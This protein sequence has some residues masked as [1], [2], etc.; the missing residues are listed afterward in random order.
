MQRFRCNSP[1][2]GE[3][4]RERARRR[5]VRGG[6]GRTRGRDGRGVRAAHVAR[7]P[8]PRAEPDLAFVGLPFQY[9]VTSD[10]LPGVGRDARRVAEHVARRARAAR[11]RGRGDVG[12]P[13]AAT[14]APARPAGARVD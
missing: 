2:P 6:A 9:A 12:P 11:R 10:V 14:V 8:P 7:A 5:L 4:V 3:T 1:P 13:D